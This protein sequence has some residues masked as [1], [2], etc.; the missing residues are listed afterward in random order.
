M[1]K[2]SLNNAP[3]TVAAVL[4]FLIAA[5][6]PVHAAAPLPNVHVRG[7][8]SDVTATALTVATSRGS[9]TLALAPKTTIVE[10]D[11]ASLSDIKPN[12]LLGVPTVPGADAFRNAPADA[13]WDWPGAGGGSSTT[14]GAVSAASH[15]TNGT[16]QLS[17]RMTNGTVSSATRSGPLTL[18][19]NYTSQ[20]G[21]KL[22]TIPAGTPV[23]RLAIADGSALKPGSYLFA[24][25]AKNNGQLSAG[26][27]IVGAPGVTVPM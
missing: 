1:S 5:D 25:A 18:T 13:V 10:A 19:L 3:V 27:I 16:V 4:S 15:M 9:V 7:T 11:P 24:F 17:S 23:V 12:S 6:V 14:N 26:I 22:V 8:I 20:A 2:Q 21:S